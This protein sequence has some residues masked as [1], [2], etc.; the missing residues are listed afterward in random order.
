LFVVHNTQDLSV[1]LSNGA[2]GS[3]TQPV[4]HDLSKGARVVSNRQASDR[5]HAVPKR[6]GH[7]SPCKGHRARVD[8]VAVET[9]ATKRGSSTLRP[10]M[11]L[12]TAQCRGGHG[13]AAADGCRERRQRRRSSITMAGLLLCSAVGPTETYAESRYFVRQMHTGCETACASAIRSCR[14][15]SRLGCALSFGVSAPPQRSVA[16]P[17]SRTTEHD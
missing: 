14:S 5:E 8:T 9:N 16:R 12:S 17:S 7:L 1:P 11:A 3:F 15:R 6:A 4:G 2:T 13:A 10:L